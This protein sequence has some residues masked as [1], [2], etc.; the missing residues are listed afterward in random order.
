MIESETGG[1]KRSNSQIMK[2]LQET[3]D[4]SSQKTSTSQAPDQRRGLPK[5]RSGLNLAQ[6]HIDAKEGKIDIKE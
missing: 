4:D 1:L 5:V 6:T 2:A 3:D